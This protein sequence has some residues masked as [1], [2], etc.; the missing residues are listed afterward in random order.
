MSGTP[1][2]NASL[3]GATSISGSVNIAAGTQISGLYKRHVGLGLVDNTSDMD[4]P[5]SNAV[6]AEIAAIKGDAVV[7]ASKPAL[8][9]LAELAAA[10]IVDL[11]SSYIIVGN[12]IDKPGKVRMSGDVTIKNDGETTISNGAVTAIKI[13]ASAVITDKLSSKAVT[14]A[15]FQDVSAGKI[16]IGN[17]SNRPTLVSMSGA[18]TI[19]NDGVTTISDNAVDTQQIAAKAV[20]ENKILNGAVTWP[21][22]DSNVTSAFSRKI[23]FLNLSNT[24][25]PTGNVATPG[26]LVYDTYNNRLYIC[27]TAEDNTDPSNPISAVWKYSDQFH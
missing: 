6:R 16:I 8:D 13:D 17:V 25:L 10:S 22:I 9:T 18:V 23:D 14:L 20:V 5:V 15:K 19:R 21:K 11:S 7:L 27:I 2:S 4:K 1:L 3:T 24:P 26:K 12:N